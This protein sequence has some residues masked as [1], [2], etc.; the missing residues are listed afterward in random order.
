MATGAFSL[1][2][3][4]LLPLEFRVEGW[5]LV[6][7]LAGGLLGMGVTVTELGLPWG[8]LCCL[9][10]LALSRDRVDLLVVG[11][12][13]WDAVEFFSFCDDRVSEWALVVLLVLWGDEELELVFSVL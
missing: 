6:G 10:L 7:V 13:D 11:P 2:T 9:A 12:G 3:A 5:E 1:L 4:S 8:V